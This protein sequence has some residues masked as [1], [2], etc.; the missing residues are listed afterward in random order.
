MNEDLAGCQRP[1]ARGI[2]RGAGRDMLLGAGR[3]EAL[4]RDGGIGLVLAPPPP[5]SAG[6]VVA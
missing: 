4:G 3:D 1:R 2:G 5:T 6:S